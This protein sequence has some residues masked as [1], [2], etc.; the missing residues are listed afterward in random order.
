MFEFI[1]ADLDHYR[2][3]CCNGRG[4]L[5]LVALRMLFAHPASAGVMHYRFGAWAWRLRVP[6][7]REAMKLLYLLALPGV[8][9]YSGVQ[10]HPATRIGRGLAILHF[11]GVVLCREC[12][13]GEHCLLHHNVSIVTTNNRQGPRIGDWFYAGVGAVLIGN[14]VVEDNVISGAGAVVTRSVP[15]DAIVGGSPARILRF[16]RADETPPRAVRGNLDVRPFL[17]APA[18]GASDDRISAAGRGESPE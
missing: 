18:V 9:L 15:R 17:T 10:L 8:R 16:R 14:L 5:L 12:E 4:P 3:W 13:I 2:Q 1:R 7:V 6:V 11:G